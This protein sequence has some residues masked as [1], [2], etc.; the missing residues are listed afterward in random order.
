MYIYLYIN[1]ILNLFERECVSIV[2]FVTF[3]KKKGDYADRRSL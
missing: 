2:A 3:K 1:N